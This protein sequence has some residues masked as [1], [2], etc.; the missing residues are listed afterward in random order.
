MKYRFGIVLT[1]TLVVF[2]VVIS[3][4]IA[5]SNYVELWQQAIQNKLNQVQQ[6]ELMAKYALETVEKA[7]NLFGNN[8]AVKMKE[9]SNYL[10]DLYDINPSFE[11][12]DF[13]TL[14]RSFSLDIYIINDQNVVIYSSYEGDIGLDFKACCK[15]LSNIL[16]QRRESGGFF[17]DGIDIE[18]KTGKMKKFSYMATRDKKYIIELSYSLEDGEIFNHF[19]FLDTINKFVEQSPSID[20]INVL[21]S[22]GIALGDYGNERKLSQ[23]RRD[24]FELTRKTGQTTEYKGEWRNEPAIYRYVQYISKYDQGTTQTKVLEIVYNEKDLRSILNGNTRTLII[25]LMIIMAIAAVISFILSKWVAKPFYLAF[26]D[27]LTGLNNRA[28]FD[29]ILDDILEKNKGTTAL[30]M[31]DLDNFKLVNDCYGHDRGDHVLKRVGQCIRDIARKGDVAVRLGGDEFVL[32]MP[33]TTKQEAAKTAETLIQS[34]GDF[35]LREIQLE[36]KKVT[37]SIGIALSPEKGADRDTL[38]KEADMALYASKKKGK[39]QYQF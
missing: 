18:Q 6:N 32:I 29:G 14:N 10:S 5:A 15:G 11:Q 7:Y 21:N 22:A 8:I 9:T 34:V 24:L 1:A 39:N 28:A 37:V 27:S 25:Q 30:M 12:W 2:A 36:G 23:E 17:H 26:H 19:N 33:N 16:D 31:I 3:L 13:A 38:L 4:A 35:T 20:E